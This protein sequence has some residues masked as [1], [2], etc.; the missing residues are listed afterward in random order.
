M[1]YL[2]LTVSE[3]NY[4]RDVDDEFWI[5]VTIYLDAY[6]VVVL[7]RVNRYWR[8]L[9]SPRV[10][11]EVSDSFLKTLTATEDAVDGRTFVSRLSW[12]CIDGILIFFPPLLQEFA[13][14]PS[15][16]EWER[17]RGTTSLTLV[18]REASIDGGIALSPNA[19]FALASSARGRIL[20]PNLKVLSVSCPGTR[21]LF[22]SPSV[23]QFSWTLDN[24]SPNECASMALAYIERM[25]SVQ[26]I[27]IQYSKLGGRGEGIVTLL[28][29]MKRLK[30]VFFPT[31]GITGRVLYY[32]AISTKVE[33][34]IIDNNI[35]VSHSWLP[36]P[37]L[38]DNFSLPVETARDAFPLLKRLSISLPTLNIVTGMVQRQ[39][40]SSGTVVDLLL[41]LPFV[42]ADRPGLL[43]RAL[44]DLS[45][46][47]KALQRIELWMLPGRTQR[48]ADIENA[49]PLSL[50]HIAPLALFP[51]LEHI[52]LHDVIASRLSDADIADFGSKIPLVR[53]LHLNPHPYDNTGITA[54][55]ASLSSLAKHCPKL[56]DLAL[57]LDGTKT[58][59]LDNVGEFHVLGHLRLGRSL[60]FPPDLFPSRLKLARFIARVTPFIA[61]Y[62][63]SG[64]PTTL[65]CIDE[66]IVSGRRPFPLSSSPEWIAAFERRWDG[67]GELIHIAR[68]ERAYEREVVARVEELRNVRRSREN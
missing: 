62:I 44:L 39:Y 22:V 53:V 28:T 17:F 37:D 8:M 24:C 20:F 57:C 51:R 32:L 9:F 66:G 4:Q 14:E 33:E 38:L 10:A 64:I 16:A 30:R 29:G 19:K 56:T 50:E 63:S 15:V 11:R 52:I 59:S 5:G 3:M 27:R 12:R 54:T 7:S 40:F 13:G 36:H 31:Y 2:F 48:Q 65:D 47:M 60:L 58:V 49:S 35:P 42:E 46:V 41:R 43:Q 68:E 18:Y 67:M 45:G 26:D 25:P 1:F 23:T 34:I 21:Q 61:A 6:D 55:F